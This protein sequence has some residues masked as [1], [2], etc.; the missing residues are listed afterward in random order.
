MSSPSPSAPPTKVLPW[1]LLGLMSFFS[2]VGPFLIFLVLK[3]GDREGWPPD[4]P[5]EWWA[6]GLIT[7]LVMIWMTAC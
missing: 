1:A 5:V 3:G 7:G 2:L 4:R 6:F